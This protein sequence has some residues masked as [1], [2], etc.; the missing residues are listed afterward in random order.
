MIYK[1]YHSTVESKFLAVKKQPRKY[2]GTVDAES[3]QDAYIKSNN[4][5]V[6]WNKENPC[7]STSVGD[8]IQRENTYFM[9]TG[10]GF[11]EIREEDVYHLYTKEEVIALFKELEAER[12]KYIAEDAT[13]IV[14]LHSFLLEKG[15]IHY[16]E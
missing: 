13:E 7:G 16:D 1:I 11:E 15:I 3:L 5:E 4:T 2:V 14:T 8:V 9:V 12:E 10:D 6:F